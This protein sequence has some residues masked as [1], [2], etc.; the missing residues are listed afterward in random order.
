MKISAKALWFLGIVALASTPA[1][2]EAPTP[3]K[4]HLE[5]GD[6]FLTD[7]KWQEAAAEY[8]KSLEAD[9]KQEK[10]WEKK[11]YCHMQAGE[12]EASEAAIL[13]T[14]DFKP[15]AAKKAE[16]YRSLAGIYMSKNAQDKAEKAFLEAAKLDP[17]DDQ[18]LSWLG[19]IYSQRGGARDMKAPGVPEA[20][21]KAIEFYD[22]AIALKPADAGAYVN[23]RIAIGKWMESERVQKEASEKAA[24]DAGADKAKADEA[25]AAAEKHK[26]KMDELKTKLDETTKKLGEAN[27]SAAAAKK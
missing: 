11:A 20:L 27:K 5:K 12:M 25:T 14:L 22:K 4:I 17:N 13:K 1:C 6:E 23:K 15:D 19:E 26:A 8:G 21:E 18:S 9:P 10:V 2:K 3:A 16:V 7:S 24:L